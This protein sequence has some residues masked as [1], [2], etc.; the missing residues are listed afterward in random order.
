MKTI[1]SRKILYSESKEVRFRSTNG[2]KKQ[3]IVYVDVVKQPQRNQYL[4]SNRC[5]IKEQIKWGNVVFSQV[6]GI[7]AV[8]QGF[9]EWE[10]L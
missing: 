10:E 6:A 9:G 8:K 5:L 1:C 4:V 3:T 7:F 2:N